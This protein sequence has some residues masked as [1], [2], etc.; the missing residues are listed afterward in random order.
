MEGNSGIGYEIAFQLARH[1]AHVYVAGRSDSRLQQAITSMR[2]SVPNNEDLHLATLI[3]DLQSLHSVKAAV[4]EFMNRESRLDLLI[5]NA[6]V[7]QTLRSLH[8]IPFFQ[9]SSTIGPGEPLKYTYLASWIHH[10]LL[11]WTKSAS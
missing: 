9:V 8:N 2:E 10:A 1:N 4:D 11:D 6:G 7:S 5:N 3:M